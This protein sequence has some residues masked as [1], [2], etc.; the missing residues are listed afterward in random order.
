V[1]YFLNFVEDKQLGWTERHVGSVVTVGSSSLGTPKG[2]AAQMSFETL[3]LAG[4]LN[5]VNYVRR[6]KEWL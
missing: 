3:E 5:Q 1:H 6:L 4:I 2:Y